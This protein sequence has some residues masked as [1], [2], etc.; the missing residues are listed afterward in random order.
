MLRKLFS[1]I[2]AALFL[3]SCALAELEIHFI[4]VGQADAAVVLCD[5]SAMMIDG[6]NIGDSQLIFSYLKNTLSLT[7][8]DAMIAT[9]PHEDHI[10]G[11]PAALNAVTVG[12]IYSPVADYDSETFGNLK[13]YAT[14]GITVP[15]IGDNF[16]LSGAT[17]TIV[18]VT[19]TEYESVNDWSIVARIDYGDTS[20]LFTGDASTLAEYDMITSGIDLDCD[21]L[22]VGHH[23]SASSSTAQFLDAVSPKYAVISVGAGNS[24]GHPTD[25]AL[26]RLSCVG[27]IVYRTDQCGTI[28]C[29][30]D[31]KTISFDAVPFTA[32]TPVSTQAVS[33]EYSYVGNKNSHK[34]HYPSCQSVS[35]MKDKN[36]VPG[37]RNNR[38]PNMKGV[39]T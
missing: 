4:D 37:G 6:G 36:K 7:H 8:V 39:I 23:G 22:K 10:G 21:V 30:S 27:A 34:L 18:N 16:Q 14:C 31:G 2:L 15:V 12:S 32:N 24:Y 33:I 11:L 25:E 35:D 28:V 26:Y 17:V 3:C 38:S 5:G 19:D 13:K 29:R 20:F 1:W 9:H